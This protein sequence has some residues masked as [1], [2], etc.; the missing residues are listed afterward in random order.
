M[1]G[2]CDRRGDERRAQRDVTAGQSFRDAHDVR[3]HEIMFQSA[4]GA[5]ASRPAHHFVGNQQNVVFAAD[6]LDGSRVAVG[7]R[8]DAAG[9]AHD[10]FEYEC[11]NALRPD[12]HDG[13]LEL[14]RKMARQIAAGYPIGQPVR[15]RR[16]DECDVEQTPLEGAAPLG[17]IRNRQGSQGI[18]VP[19]PAPRDEAA[20][21]HQTA[22]GKMLEGD[23]QGRF[24]RFRPAAG[25][26][27]VPEGAAAQ[28]QNRLGQAFE[29]GA[30]E[31]IP[32]GV[33]DLMQLLRDG[34]IDHG[35]GVPKAE[36]RGAAG[37]VEIALSR[38]VE[39]VTA[40]AA[41]DARQ[42]LDSE[43]AGAAFH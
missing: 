29:R 36:H 8:H 25:V 9:R 10:G 40:L 7:R 12:G 32:I 4:P 13:V 14:R 37:A 34:R 11:G 5:A 2:C 24:D 33:R 6:G 38:G 39:Q 28:A 41:H 18:A 3:D 19:R 20:F 35:M 22:G 42:F 26:Y 16:G 23:L 21:L 27:D 1:N 17:K 15:V 30:R 31:Q 43:P